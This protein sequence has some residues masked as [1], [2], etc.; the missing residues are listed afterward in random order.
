[1]L[2]LL[3]SPRFALAL[4]K[5]PIHCSAGVWR[6][7]SGSVSSNYFPAVLHDLKTIRYF[8]GYVLDMS[9][10][11]SGR[12]I[13]RL[14]IHAG[15]SGGSCAVLWQPDIM[16]KDPGPWARQCEPGSMASSGDSRAWAVA[17]LKSKCELQAKRQKSFGIILCA[18]ARRLGHCRK[19]VDTLPLRREFK[20]IVWL[21]R[22]VCVAQITWEEDKEQLVE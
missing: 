1:M 13:S 3:Q 4:Q 18:L 6:K 12:A 21:M 20:S 8:T 10:P 11:L 16:C 15:M 5:K 14:L 17:K 2:Q 9:S 22:L 19:M 7:T